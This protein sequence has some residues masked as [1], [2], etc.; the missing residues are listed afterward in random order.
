MAGLLAGSLAVAGSAAVQMAAQ[1]QQQMNMVQALTGSN[2]QQMAF[3]DSQVKKLAID[4][5]EAPAKLASGLYNVLSA[6]Y[7]GA[8]AMRILTLATQDAKIGLTSAAITSNAL[9]NVLR[10]FGITAKDATRVN[11]EM[12]ETVTL[13]KATFAQYASTITNAASASKQ[14]HVS[15]ETMNAAWSTLTSTGISAGKATTDY[16]QLLSVMYGNI[17]TVTKSLARNGIAFNETKFNAMSFGDK[18]QYLNSVLEIANQK[19]VHITGVTKQ[20]AQAIQAISG[21]IGNYNS[22]LKTLSDH[23][24]MAS[25]T[26]QAWAITQS[27]FSQTMSR[28]GAAIQVVLINIGQQ[29]LPVLTQLAQAVLPIIL[30]L[31]TW[32]TKSG[33]ITAVTNG[34]IG[35][36]KT[37]VSWG[38]AVVG[39]FQ[40]NQWAVALLIGALAG[41]VVGGLAFVATLIPPLIA[42]FVAWA[43]A[44]G[45]AALATL[46][47][48]LPFIL[49]G[50]AVMALV[51]II[52]LLVT[53]WS[54]VIAFLRGAWQA[55]SS[56][57]MGALHAVGQFFANLWSGITSGVHFAWSAIVSA[58]Q[59]GLA[60]LLNVFL[61]PFRAIGQ[62]FVWL[63]QHNTYFQ[64]LVDAIRHSIS[65]GLAWLRGAWQGAIAWL[66]GLWNGIAGIASR[67]WNAL[68][69]AIVTAVLAIGKWE[70]DQ[71]NKAVGWLT[72][73]WNSLAGLAGKAWGLVSGVFGSIWSKYIAGPLGNLWNQFTSWFGNLAKSA[74]QWG[75]NLIQGF[76]NG[77]MSM[78]GKIK[79]AAGNI[80]KNVAGFLGF[81]SPAKEGEGRYVIEWGQGL[82][83]GFSSGVIAAIPS[84][85][86]AVNMAVSQGTAPMQHPPAVIPY[87]RPPAGNSY[88]SYAGG[89]TH[90][91][92]IIIHA[93]AGM[94]VKELADEIERRQNSKLRRSG[95]LGNP[96]RGMRNS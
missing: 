65:V 26:Q 16:T 78:L 20:A 59:A 94:N 40:K 12:L 63:Y 41:L 79:D 58:V 19:H 51:T 38:A 30:A 35:V 72:D 76:I 48:A 73:K 47:A 25:K 82:M 27:G 69:T 5:G 85:Q 43:M 49:I 39:F 42:S 9:T 86:A 91:G 56:W 15:L 36:I 70:I 89:N 64:R 34:V 57:F 53:H 88:S 61:S 24:A 18:V 77:L 23:Q 71:W 44:A 3:Y 10:T 11:G 50:L 96:A 33:I 37:L 29:L 83:K 90:N 13:G 46:A 81:H 93:P 21:H 52:L 28:V 95:V 14:F 1:Y 87:G 2:A 4:A 55:F 74:L 32:I 84:L 62:L 54:Q 22:N 6:S 7:T 67:A 66:T 8:D 17:G 75:I 80:M 60:F 31:A 92:D 68:K 45:A